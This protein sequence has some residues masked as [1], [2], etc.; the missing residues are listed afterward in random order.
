[1]DQSV[2]A[3][4]LQGKEVTG[5]MR[6]ILIDW[7]VQVNLKFRLLQ[8]T[9]YMTVGIIDRFLQVG[10]RSQTRLSNPGVNTNW[11][12]SLGYDRTI[13][14]PRSSFSS[15]ESQPCFLLPNTRRCI[16]LRFQTLPMWLTVP[17]PL[18]RLGTWRWPSSECSSLDWAAP[19]L[20]SSSE[21]LQ[22]SMKFVERQT[23]FS[24]PL[25]I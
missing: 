5:N 2:R 1:M 14:S 10:A 7:L 11:F 20:C 24:I 16:L 4:F 25:F 21:E 18:R 13:Q 12:L 17:T 3:A 6:A 9:M 22:R 15:L 23:W 19:C 8:E